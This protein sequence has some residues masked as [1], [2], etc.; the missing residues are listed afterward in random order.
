MR[1]ITVD[2]FAQPRGLPPITE[3]LLRQAI[4]DTKALGLK[5]EEAQLHFADLVEKRQRE[6]FRRFFIAACVACRGTN[7]PFDD[8]ESRNDWARQ[9]S[10]IGKGHRVKVYE[11]WKPE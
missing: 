11:E 9:H 8:L 5:G 10:R 2:A 1:K 7:L 3:K 6:G 4:D